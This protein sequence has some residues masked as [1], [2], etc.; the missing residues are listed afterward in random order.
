MRPIVLRSALALACVLGVIAGEAVGQ[1]EVTAWGNMT[2]IRLGGHRMAFE[3]SLLAVGV[4]GAET[5]RTAKERQQPRYTRDGNQQIV[6]T[7]LDSLGFTQVVTDVGPGAV[8]VEIEV[9]SKEELAVHGVYFSLEIPTDLAGGGTTQ[10]LDPQDATLVGS[11]PMHGAAVKTSA[12]G[13][14]IGAPHRQLRVMLEEPGEISV[15]DIGGGRAEVR[16][17]LLGGGAEEGQTVQKKLNL[18]ATGDIDTRPVEL[19]LDTARPGRPFEGFGGNF[20]IQNPEVDPL[21]IRYN[22]DNLKVTWG[23]VEMPWRFWH[24]EEDVDPIEAARAGQLHQRVRQAMEMAQDLHRRDIPVMLAAWSGPDWAMEGTFSFGQERGGLRGLPLDQTKAEKI[25]ASLTAYIRYLQDEFGVETVAFSFNESDLGINVRQT[26]E[27]HAKLIRELGAFFKK[28]GLQTKLLLGDTA[29]GNGYA[30][31]YAA[32]K[33]PATHPYIHAV[34]FH[35]W[36]GWENDTLQRWAEVAAE[37]N[38]PLIVGEGSTDAAAHR[39]PAIFEELVY[40]LEEI[41]LYIRMLA[42][43]QTQSIIQWQLTGDYSILAG[44]GVYGNRNEPLRP[45]RRFWNLKQLAAMPTGLFA[46]PVSSNRALVTTAALGDSLRGEYVVH[47]VNN[48]AS[49]EA[50]LT[51]L[52]DGVQELDVF[53]TDGRREMEKGRRIQVK[54]GQARFSLEATSFTTLHGLRENPLTAD[55]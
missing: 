37:L 15:S 50:L 36:R 11:R 7:Q 8:T 25:Y 19:S 5:L 48:G 21:V 20:R 34:S 12:K 1:A 6:T 32:L 16:F 52:P 44:G 43:C 28:S 13:I 27:E 29:D 40:S 31:T 18:T 55:R 2:G 4:R 54:A 41:N 14:L 33:D 3:S 46:M 23:R 10:L 24:P 17:T 35:S 53:V 30:F 47:I 26:A 9:T 49:R 22:L 38:L 51:G 42:I 39:Y 45:T